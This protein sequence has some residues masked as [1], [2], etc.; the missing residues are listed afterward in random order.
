M[1][2]DK[3]K[4]ELLSRLDKIVTLL[5]VSCNISKAL[6]ERSQQ[7]IAQPEAPKPQTVG[8]GQGTAIPSRQYEI[9]DEMQENYDLAVQRWKNGRKL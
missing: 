6:L 3:F 4:V 7:G 5:T 8:A 2:D 1:D 9:K